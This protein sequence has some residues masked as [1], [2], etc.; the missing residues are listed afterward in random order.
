M[1]LAKFARSNT[2]TGLEF[3]AGMPG[4][5]GGALRMNAGAYG[6]ETKDCLIEAT[7]V[8]RSGELKTLKQAELDF[9]YRHC[10]IPQIGFLLRGDLPAKAESG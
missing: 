9:G 10:G 6:R 7:L 1:T 5:I 2:R 4:T 3:Y 8:T